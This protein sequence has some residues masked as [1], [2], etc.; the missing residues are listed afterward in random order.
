MRSSNKASVYIGDIR[1]YN[2]EY[3]IESPVIGEEEVEVGGEEE[4]DQ[5][6]CPNNQT[7]EQHLPEFTLPHQVS[8]T[9]VIIY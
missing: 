2:D 5:F 6:E 8:S 4:A 1:T 3:S 7:V 9:M